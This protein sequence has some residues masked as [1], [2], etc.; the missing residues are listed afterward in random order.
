LDTAP[1]SRPFPAEL[2]HADLAHAQLEM[3]WR[4]ADPA[5][6]VI[7]VLPGSHDERRLG[8]ILGIA[9]ACGMPVRGMV[10]AA[11]AGAAYASAAGPLLH[12]DLELHRTV[13]TELSQTDALKRV[14]VEVS[15]HTGIASLHD[16]WAKRIAATFVQRTRFDPLHAAATEQLLY[17]RLPELLVQLGNSAVARLEFAPGPAGQPRAVELGLDDL[18][19][20]A[21]AAYSGIVQ[22]VRLFKRAGEDPTLLLSHRAA[23]LPGLAARLAEVADAGVIA[24]PPE[25]AL[26]GALAQSAAIGSSGENEALEFVTSLPVRVARAARPRPLSADRR[27]E[28]SG[29]A[30]APTHLLHEGLA[31][32]ILAEPLAV[33][34]AVPEAGRG[35]QLGG[36]TAGISRRHCSVFIR[37]GRV[38][39]EDHST[40]G[41]FL[42]GRRFEG[43]AELSVG[44]RLRVGSPGIELKLIRL[45][46]HDGASRD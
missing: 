2:S 36:G 10:D 40:Y 7:L 30:V 25:A 8:L 4:A 37:R 39:V 38:W 33:G 31:H 11:V 43:T 24:L 29:A 18:T 17:D 9:R 46:E 6:G 3:L 22:L 12:V 19:G 41:S 15:T 16:A 28:R 13:L 35:L 23:G 26:A 34:L 20:A 27:S 44:D 32:P 21:D 14:R 45:V 42:N 1:L 5:E